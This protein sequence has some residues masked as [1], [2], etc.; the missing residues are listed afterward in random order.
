[1]RRYLACLPEQEQAAACALLIFVDLR[2]FKA[3]GLRASSELESDYR[4][5]L[6]AVRKQCGRGERA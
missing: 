1:M 3:V 2:R 5:A 6:Q 4:A